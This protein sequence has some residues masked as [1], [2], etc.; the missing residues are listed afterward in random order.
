MG[1]A[2]PAAAI[3]EAVLHAIDLPADVGVDELVVRPRDD[4]LGHTPWQEDGRDSWGHPRWTA[5]YEGWPV[6]LTKV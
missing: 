6:P 5:C 4:G 3:S 1:I 2:I